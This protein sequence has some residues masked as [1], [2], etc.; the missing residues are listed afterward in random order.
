MGHGNAGKLI[1]CAWVEG[2]HKSGDVLL[3][4]VCI[5]EDASVCGSC[6]LE[7]LIS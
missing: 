4:A 3:H 2:A 5:V 6:N 1:R 7:S